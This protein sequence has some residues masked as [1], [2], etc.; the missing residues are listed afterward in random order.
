MCEAH[1]GPHQG[2]LID[3]TEAVGTVLAHDITEVRPGEYKGTAF[4]KGYVVRETDLDH[5][6]RLGKQHLYVLN[7]EPGMMHEDEAVLVLAEALAGR[8]IDFSPNPS[9]GKINLTA[10]WDGLLKVNVGAL[11]D[12]NTVEGVMCASRHTNSLVKKGDLVAGTRA[13]PLVIQRERVLEAAALVGGSTGGV[14]TVKPLARPRTGLVVTGNEVYSG[15]IQDKFVPVIKPKLA[16]FECPVM[17]VVFTPDDADVIARTVTGLIEQGA[18]MIVTTGG[19]SVDPDDVTRVGVAAAGAEEVL[20]GASVLPGAMLLLARIG[21]VPIIGVPA[22]GMFHDQTIFDLVLPRILAGETLTRRDLAALGHGGLCLSC[23][24][25][26][27]PC[28][29][30]GKSG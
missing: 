10:A 23:P 14:F 11:T 20:Y 3:L 17:D 9:E 13:I 15:L 8:G 4:K 6:A 21:S 30:F 26:R 1:F 27:Y 12:F 18:E 25:C 28:C 16:A 19:M 29:P 7:L 22:C 2:R 5:L 24:S